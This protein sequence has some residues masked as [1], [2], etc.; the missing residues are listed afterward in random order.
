MIPGKRPPRARDTDQLARRVIDVAAGQAS[1]EMP[2]PT[3][4][5]IG[6]HG[7][8]ASMTPQAR[9]GAGSQGRASERE[10]A[11][12]MGQWLGGATHA[13]R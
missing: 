5:A 11:S 4:R 2:E 1:D 3:G 7:R 10:R 6:G 9:L 8:A 13:I 12:G